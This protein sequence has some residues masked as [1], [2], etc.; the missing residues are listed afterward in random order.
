MVGF[1]V[2]AAV[3]AAVARGEEARGARCLAQGRA[4]A[5][6]AL[7]QE[8]PFNPPGRCRGWPLLR[9]L[10]G[11]VVGVGPRVSAE[12]TVV[13]DVYACGGRNATWQRSLSVFLSVYSDT[14]RDAV[15]ARAPRGA[16]SLRLAWTPPEAGAYTVVP[17]LHF[18]GDDCDGGAPVYL[19]GSEP[20]CR[21][22]AGREKGATLA[23][24]KGSSLGRFSTRLG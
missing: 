4:P 7:A 24:F 18:Y 11:D 19:G 5:P 14:V 23:N 20:R 13:L 21:P 2:V 17:R 15:L 10:G 22:R 6:S 3:V 9:R 1:A 16:S 12:G 8:A